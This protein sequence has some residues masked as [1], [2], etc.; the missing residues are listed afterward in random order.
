[1]E[2]P[3]LSPAKAI[4]LAVQLT[5]ESRISSLRAIVA[6]HPKTLHTELVLRILLSHLPETLE[7]SEY[8]PF[9]Q[10]LKYGTLEDDKKV[11]VDQDAFAGLGDTEA[12]RQVR[13]LG[14][15][16]LA[17]PNSPADAPADP[18]VQF[19]IHRSLRIDEYTGL[20]THLP[21]LLAPFLHLSPYLRT[22]FISSVLPLLRLNYEYYPDFATGLTIPKFESLDDRAGVSLLL[23]GSGQNDTI[24]TRD[25]TTIG[26]DLRGLVGPW[27]YGDSRWKR[28]RLRENS[29]FERPT[30]KPQDGAPAPDHKYAAWEEV[31]NWIV[32]EAGTTW[33]LVVDAVEQW[34]GPGDVDLGGF[35]DGTTWLDEDEQQYLE[36][37]YARAV[38]AA[39]Y[40]IPEESEE[41]LYGI[42]RILTR[43]ITLLDKDRIPTLQVATA[44]LSPVPNFDKNVFVLKNTSF[45]R[46]DLLGEYNVLT[47][48][49]E[50]SIS[51]LHALLISSFLCTRVGCFL[52][53]KRAGELVL[54]QDKSEQNQLFSGVIS[55]IINGPKGDD[56]FWI[57]IRKELLW[58]RSWD[59][60]ESAEST[61]SQPGRG[62]FGSLPKSFIETQILKALL[63]NTRQ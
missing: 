61:N 16:P 53:I 10:D 63:A 8:V 35:E 40:L 18:L 12:R 41:A 23:A 30:I 21:I 57:K 13:K 32:N 20:L 9:L 37:R 58:L 28:R 36:R 38:I 7:S 47:N 14:L 56:K 19:L 45:L 54:L 42:Q 26:R 11:T 39:A 22:W 62:I 3:N 25:Y 51:L 55:N 2:S 5:A 4:L 34:D 24:K 59:S 1:M 6:R 50:D 27:M 15:L 44:L 31:F 48:P 49:N 33:K 29:L 43:I 60:E 17:W 52:S 46:G